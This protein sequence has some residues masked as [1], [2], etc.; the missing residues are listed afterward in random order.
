M[1]ISTW[2]IFFSTFNTILHEQQVGVDVEP[3]SI[4]AATQNAVLN[5]VDSNFKALICSPRMSDPDPLIGSY[6][7]QEFDM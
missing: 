1:W 3:L 2:S 5:D 6:K 4:K 7:K